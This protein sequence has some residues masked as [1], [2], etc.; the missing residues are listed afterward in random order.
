LKFRDLR[1]LLKSKGYVLE[2]QRRTSH[3]QWRN[4]HRP[5][6]PVTVSG[7]DREEVPT[8]ILADTL[9]RMGLR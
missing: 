8:G 2:R 9:K 6:Q 5:G 4:P 3:Q 7:H 1:K